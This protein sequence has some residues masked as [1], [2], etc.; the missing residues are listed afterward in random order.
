MAHPTRFR[1]TSS[2]GLML[3]EVDPAQFDTQLRIFIIGNEVVMPKG[4]HR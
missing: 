1:L 4:G 2:V 3:D